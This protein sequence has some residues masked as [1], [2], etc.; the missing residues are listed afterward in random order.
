MIRLYGR[1]EIAALPEAESGGPVT[2]LDV[3]LGCQA[4]LY[5]WRRESVTLAAD[6]EKVDE[7]LQEFAAMD[8]QYFA[9]ANR[10]YLAA[11]HEFAAQAP[12]GKLRAA[13][14]FPVGTVP[15]SH[16]QSDEG[17]KFG[18]KETALE[19]PPPPVTQ[20]TAAKPPVKGQPVQPVK[21]VKAPAV[22]NAVSS[23]PSRRYGAWY[24]ALLALAGLAAILWF[25]L[26]PAPTITLHADRT[27]VTQGEP[28]HLAWTA[29]NAESVSIEPA[30]ADQP[31]NGERDVYPN[32][33]TTY[34]A[35]ARG[36][37]ENVSAEIA[38]VVDPLLSITF[39]ADD[40]SISRGSSTT[41]RWHVSGAARVT[42][43]DVGEVK[44]I[45]DVAVHPTGQQTYKLIATRPSGRVVDKDVTIKVTE[46]LPPPEPTPPP[47][48]K[49]MP[50]PTVPPSITFTAVPRS[51]DQCS[52][53][54][55]K[56]TVRNATRV[57]IDPVLANAGLSGS[58][59][60]QLSKDET[61][62]LTASGPGG[63]E[64]REVPV[65]VRS[66][67]RPGFPAG[68]GEI[69]WKGVATAGEQIVIE[70]GRGGPKSTPPAHSITG[71]IPY[72][73]VRVTARESYVDVAGQPAS[74]GIAKIILS[75]RRGGLLTIHLWWERVQ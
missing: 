17:K 42:I 45:G 60:I 40:D 49:K 73:N 18:E 24:A 74:L 39:T 66:T 69:V 54:T 41:L 71:W 65:T 56:W 37:R 46:P 5:W 43:Q 11:P 25:I 28:V 59:D 38:V 6:F 19:D 20:P 61:F 22:P 58:F 36:R 30:L 1:Y 75:P 34:K 7:A 50:T 27:V 47:E 72:R 51:I 12:L 31:A 4:V 21:P 67:H 16:V 48:P 3:M 57:S 70:S 33:N 64:E 29:T 9:D 35:V 14:M 68:C 55:L 44:P 2:A 13:G 26:T 53:T 52:S 10:I 63:D 15:P 32:Q 62:T 8:V 23:P